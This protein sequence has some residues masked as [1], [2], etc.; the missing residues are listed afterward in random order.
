MAKI[1]KI[2]LTG[3]P[4]AGKTTALA[5]IVDTFIS[6][7]FNVYC[8]PEAATLFNQAGINFLTP[9]KNFFLCAEKSL[10][11][12]QINMESLF[13]NMAKA[14]DKPALIICDR[15]T[16]DIKAYLSETDWHNLLKLSEFHEVTLRDSG[17][18]AIIHMHTAAK[19]AE[20]FY[21]LENNSSRTESLDQARELD[22]KLIRAWTGHPHLRIIANEGS[23]EEKLNKTVKEIADVLGVPVS[24]EKEKKYL[25]EIIG[26]IPDSVDNDI[27]QTY[28]ISDKDS[29][30]RVRKR[31]NNGGFVYFHTVKNKL[32][33]DQRIETERQ[34]SVEEYNEFL[35]YADPQKITIHK[36]RKCFVYE[37]QYF[38]LDR[39]VYPDNKINLL[40]IEG[41]YTNEQIKF[42]PYLKILEEVTENSDYYNINI[43]KTK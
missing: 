32:S 5:K 35:K 17:Y 41:D 7:G 1:T 22:D 11:S 4:C 27:F 14:S 36:V 15:G 12:F 6:K 39:Y 42:P 16:M 10:L 21:T 18:D 26:N 31:G 19:G 20:K 2:V 8:L 29:E 37:N 43:A 24:V 34:I 25:V 30:I 38:E 28:L 13:E 33:S 9:D 3:G 40:E 23:F